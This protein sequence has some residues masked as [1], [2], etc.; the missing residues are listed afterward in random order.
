MLIAIIKTNPPP[1]QPAG[2]TSPAVRLVPGSPRGCT[3]SVMSRSAIV[4]E[5]IGRRAAEATDAELHEL[6]SVAC[7]AGAVRRAVHRQHHVDDPRLPRALARTDGIPAIRARRRKPRTNSAVQ[8]VRDAAVP[9][10]E[11]VLRERRRVRGG[12]GHDQ[13]RAPSRRDRARLRHR[14]HGRRFRADLQP[15]A[16][17]RRHEAVGLSGTRS[18]PRAGSRSSRGSSSGPASCTRK[19]GP[20]NRKTLASSPT[21][22]S[23]PRGRPWSS[24]SRHRSSTAAAWRCSTATSRRGVRSGSSRATNGWCTAAP[25]RVRLRRRSASRRSR[26]VGSPPATSS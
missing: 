25:P 15:D 16:D 24:R 10:H 4:Y 13:R 3:G 8:L 14:L 9:R 21:P 18:P 6:E 12:D 26:P 5:A 1:R 7:P 22:P 2:S 23:R 20:S 19:R 11:E 17:H